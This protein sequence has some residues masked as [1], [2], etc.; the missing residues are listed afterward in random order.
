MLILDNYMNND[1]LLFEYG[2]KN[3]VLLIYTYYRPTLYM[4]LY[5]GL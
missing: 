5:C 1:A 2:N 3:N 4:V